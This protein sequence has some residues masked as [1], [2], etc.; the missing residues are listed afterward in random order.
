MN[1][2]MLALSIAFAL[3][4]TP[5]KLFSQAT[6]S[7]NKKEVTDSTT[8]K[9]PKGTGYVK[10]ITTARAISLLE[11]LLGLIGIVI[12]WRAKTRSTKA[13]G[14]TAL[15][16]GLLAITLSIAHL[17]FTSGSVFGSGSG[18]AGAI[19]ALILGLVGCVLG[20]SA[21]RSGFAE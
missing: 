5:T 10:G 8:S 15:V 21:L 9:S 1:K 16:L 18:K 12:G 6:P 13:G 4:T 2:I 11:A 14:R 3:L 7:E 19:L 17:I 20:G